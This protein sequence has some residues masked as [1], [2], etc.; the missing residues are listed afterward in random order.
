M[1]LDVR[2]SVFGFA[3]NKGAEQPAQSDQRLCYL[4]KGIIQTF[5]HMHL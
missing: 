5:F 3:N 2:K 1:G 4:L